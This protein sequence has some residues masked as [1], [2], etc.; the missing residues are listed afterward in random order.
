QFREKE[1]ELRARA[2]EESQQYQA[3]SLPD[4]PAAAE[5]ANPLEGEPSAGQGRTDRFRFRDKSGLVFGPMSAAT[6]TN[7]LVSTPL[8][9]DDRVSKNDGEWIAIASIPEIY[10]RVLEERKA[11]GKEGPEPDPTPRSG[12]YAAIQPPAH[13]PEL[14]GHK[15]SPVAREGSLDQMPFA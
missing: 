11:Q 10:D 14:S 9:E 8:H 2:L 5:I 7:L 1:A 4:T 15:P 3:I 13:S 6:L 12:H